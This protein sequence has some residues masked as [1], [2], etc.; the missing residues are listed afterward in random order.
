[1]AKVDLDD[2]MRKPQF[3]PDGDYIPRI[4]FIDKNGNVRPEIINEKGKS[5]YKYFYFEEKHLINS[6]HT[7]IDSFS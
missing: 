2:E 7:V 3:A 4:L 5:A 6:M 1:M